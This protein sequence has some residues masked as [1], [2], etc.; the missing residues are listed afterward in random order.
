MRELPFEVVR[1]EDMEKLETELT[2]GTAELD[3]LKQSILDLSHPNCQM[4]LK[5][6]DALKSELEH[7]AEQCL[8]IKESAEGL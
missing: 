5:E 1:A 8:I 7:Y 6:R 3:F 2:A 4:L